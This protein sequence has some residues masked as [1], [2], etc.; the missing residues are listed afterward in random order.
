[1]RR[2]ELLKTAALA[3]ASASS[4]ASAS[5]PQIDL[6]EITVD[7]IGKGFQS[8]RFSS[9][10]LVEAYLA[11][12]D[13]IDRR[14]PAIH[15]VIEINPD[16]LKVA[17]EL[18]RERQSKGPRSPLHGVPVLVKDNIDTAGMHTTAG[19]LALFDAPSPKDALL[20]TRL[21]AAGAVLLGK[22]NLSEW[23]N[24]RGQHS[25]SGWSARG[26]QTKNPYALN[27][28]PSGSSSGSGAAVGA[29]DE[30]SDGRLKLPQAPRNNVS[31]EAIPRLAT[32]RALSDLTMAF[33]RTNSW[34]PHVAANRKTVAGAIRSNGLRCCSD[35]VSIT[36]LIRLTKGL[37]AVCLTGS[38]PSHISGRTISTPRARLL[39]NA[40][41]SAPRRR[42]IRPVFPPLRLAPNLKT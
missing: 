4:A 2:R 39:R 14:G 15:A 20:V 36:I 41:Y 5:N 11:R 10:T 7:D 34:P 40:S 3:V 9:K 18:D 19:S 22:T 33:P 42:R 30:D 32:V 8:G 1:M 6:E 38:A 29:D 37:T 17:A 12:I 28:N 16:A 23:A 31:A 13:A 24:F 21:R 27:R 26:G 35:L 25:T